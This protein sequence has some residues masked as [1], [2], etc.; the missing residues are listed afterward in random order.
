[1]ENMHTDVRVYR[2]KSES[3]LDV[4]GFNNR[5]WVFVKTMY[6][7]IHSSTWSVSSLKPSFIPGRKRIQTFGMMKYLTK[8]IIDPDKI[9]QSAM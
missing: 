6:E 7:K 5:I 1:M 4:K 9:S 8:H 2:V 3:R